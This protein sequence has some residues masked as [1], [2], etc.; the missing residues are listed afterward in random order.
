MEEC[1]NIEFKDL[2]KILDSNGNLKSD[3][4]RDL[5]ITSVAFANVQGGNIIIGIENKDKEPPIEQIIDIRVTNET[6]SRLRS[7]CFNVGLF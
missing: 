4:L 5:A 1:Y 7:L 6:I 2:R 3:G